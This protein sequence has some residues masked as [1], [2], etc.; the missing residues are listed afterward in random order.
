MQ[1]LTN[2]TIVPTL[3]DHRPQG[4]HN[5]F[6]PYQLRFIND[7]SRKRIVEKSRQVGI[8]LT[9]AYDL[10]RKTSPAGNS[11]D[12]WVSSRDGFQAQLF[13]QDCANWAR[14]L[15]KA[16]GPLGHVLIDPEQNISGHLLP[17]A[18]GRGIY[19]LSS[20]PNA[21]AGKRGHR[22]FDE[23]ALNPDNRQL[24][25]IG[26]PGT[27]WGGGL[28]I[29]STH[30]GTGNFFNE[31]INEIKHR[32]NPRGFSLHTI[33]ILDA[34]QQGLLTKLKAKWALAN[35]DDPRLAWSP[36]DFLQSL[37]NECADEETWLQEFMCLPGDDQSAFL[38]YDLIS[39]CEY[40]P[41][42]PWETDLEAAQNHLFL[43]VDVGRDHDLTVFWLIERVANCS[44]TRRVI[45]LD[46]QSFEAQE[47]QLYQLLALPRLRRCCID[48]TGIGRQFVE[49]A[50]FRA[51]RDRVEGV[52]FT[53]TTKESLAFPVRAAFEDRTLRIPNDKLIRADLRAIRKETTS[54]GNIRFTA[55]RGK[56]GH[57][58]RFW[59]LALAL[60]AVASPANQRCLW[61]MPRA[62]AQAAAR[63]RRRGLI[64]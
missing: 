63:S 6:L 52:T 50:Q 41:A 35:P 38:S 40:P 7:P 15:H 3:P 57:A 19:C 34:V 46:R 24:Y 59:A 62:W 26:Q 22:I 58:D 56:N 64:G 39:A 61:V 14:L 29:I 11:S 27:L 36:D 18:N 17:L 8:S 4:I 53:N 47:E 43:G 20:N 48:Q 45:T 9:A 13:G 5:F 44:F 2:N 30:R 49:R 51:S 42:E 32:G 23:F 12:A 1:H 16:A 31:L 33:T 28:D 55:D 10:V 37:R 25:A 60:H 54:S 21:Q